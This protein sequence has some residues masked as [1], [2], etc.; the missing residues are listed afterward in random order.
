MTEQLGLF[1]GFGVELEYMVVEAET[2][3]IMPVVDRILAAQAGKIVSEVEVGPLAWSNE[4][5]LHV[6]EL[7]TNGP[8]PT[9]AGI[10]DTFHSQVGKVNRI[11]SGM[12][13]MLL[14]TA[15]HPWMDPHRE[16]VLWPHEFSP[17][18]QAYDRIFGCQGHGW[19]N[20]QSVHLNL[21]FRDQEEFGRLHAAIRLILPLLPGI[22]ASSPLVEGRPTGFLDSRMEY[23]R[24]NSR[25]VPSV[26]GQVIPEAVFTPWEYRETILGGMFRDIAPLDPEGILQDEFLNSRGAIPRFGRG[27]I[28]IRVLDIQEHPGADL[29]L[30]AL[31]V[32]ALRLLVEETLSSVTQQ[33]GQGSDVLVSVFQECVRKGHSALVDAPSYLEVLGFPGGRGEVREIWLHLLEEARSAHLLPDP[34]LARAAEAMVLRG[35]LA[36]QILEA[37]G[38]KEHGT[39]TPGA[40]M[41]REALEEVYR[42]LASCLRDGVLFFGR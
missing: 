21:P 42:D 29:A 37:L 39:G 4:L 22:A 41:P 15:M 26:T 5:V 19:S 11:L 7:K 2:L 33:K 24:H 8:A 13:G 1:Q 9:L 34:V 17:V 38:I 6:V 40:P 10:Q 12:G 23:Y 20:L 28:E 30:L 31:T 14:P 27:S 32:A 3:D 18:Y 25:R 36:T 35:T 16:T